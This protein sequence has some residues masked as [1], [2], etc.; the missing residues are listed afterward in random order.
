MN[1]PGGTVNIHGRASVR[2]VAF[3]NTCWAKH[4]RN[5]RCECNS[6]MY[7]L[8]YWLVM[9]NV[10]YSELSTKVSWIAFHLVCFALNEKFIVVL[11]TRFSAV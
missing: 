1:F 7:L 10:T 11:V 8:G 5:T 2:I 9:Q 4:V 6:Y 3:A